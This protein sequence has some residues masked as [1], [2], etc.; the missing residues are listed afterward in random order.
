MDSGMLIGIPPA[1]AMSNPPRPNPI[2]NDLAL[3][4]SV[5]AGDGASCTHLLAYAE[6]FARTHIRRS[7]PLSAHDDLV[8]GFLAHLWDGNWRR[9]R[10]WRAEAPLAHYLAR[11]FRNYQ[12]DFLRTLA[13]REA[14]SIEDADYDPTTAHPDDLPEL[15]LEAMQ[16]RECLDKGIE[17]VTP[18]QQE[19][20]RLRHEQSLMHREIAERLGKAL[21]TIASN[22]AD[23][24]RALK[25]RMQGECAELLEDLLGT[26]RRRPL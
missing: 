21:G 16:L 22:L 11:L 6:T 5:L 8:N 4:A 19:L 12:L 23:A 2:Q 14:S 7:V 17:R 18:N 24:E 9:L 3:I 20:L 1:Q 25:R 26:E 15:A 10:A 13:A